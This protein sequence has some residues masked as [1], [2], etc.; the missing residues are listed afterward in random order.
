MSLSLY[1][2]VFYPVAQNTGGSQPSTQWQKTTQAKHLPVLHPTAQSELG[3]EFPA[4]NQVTERYLDP[5]A[6]GPP[7]AAECGPGQVLPSPEAPWETE[8]KQ[9]GKCSSSWGS[10]ISYPLPNDNG[11][12]TEDQGSVIYPHR[13]YQQGSSGELKWSQKNEADQDNT[14]RTTSKL[15]LKLPPAGWGVWVR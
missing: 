15:S 13:R 1:P 9:Q 11:K 2:V 8:W 7:S 14:E 5:L 10:S 6:P 3:L 12:P 4:L